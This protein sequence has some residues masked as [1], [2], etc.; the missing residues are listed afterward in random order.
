MTDFNNGL[1]RMAGEYVGL[2][3]QVGKSNLLTQHTLTL[4]FGLIE[5]EP[6]S[7]GERKSPSEIMN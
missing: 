2:L 3:R 6:E 7:V 1:G 5:V 4:T